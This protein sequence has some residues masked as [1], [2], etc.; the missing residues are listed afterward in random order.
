MFQEYILFLCLSFTFCL[1]L[2]LLNLL[3]WLQFDLFYLSLAA[4]SLFIDLVEPFFTVLIMV[5]LLFVI[6]FLPLSQL[7]LNTDLIE[8]LL[9]SFILGE[10]SE[11]EAVVR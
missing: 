6:L 7:L 10:F 1:F 11:L 5:L 9:F 3:G 2:E 4:A 8:G